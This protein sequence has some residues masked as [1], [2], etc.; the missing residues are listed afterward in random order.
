MA[1]VKRI[2]DAQKRLQGHSRF[3]KNSPEVKPINRLWPVPDHLED[4]GKK[5]YHRVGAVLIKARLLTEL[6]RDSFLLLASTLDTIHEATETLQR[7]GYTVPGTQ[8]SLKAHPA[9][10]LKKNAV[11]DFL[12]LCSKF[13]LTPKDRSQ[14]DIPVDPNADDPA[15]AFLFG[16]KQC[17][18]K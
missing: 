17:K 8:G 10:S 11:A 7:D 2:P 15:R 1:D 13:G 14:L 3:V 9:I 6:D 12:T 18:R 5:F 4:H 16:G